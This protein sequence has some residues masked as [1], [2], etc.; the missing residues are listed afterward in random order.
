MTISD[1]DKHNIKPLSVLH[2]YSLDG[3]FEKGLID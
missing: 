2:V 3:V 1:A